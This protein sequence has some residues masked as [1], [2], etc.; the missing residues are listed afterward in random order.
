MSWREIDC[1][2][3]GQKVKIPWLWVLGLEMI[4]YCRGCR[5]HFKID[6]KL[7][8]LLSGA[9]WALAFASL[10]LIAYPTSA[11]TIYLAAGSFI[12]LGLLFSFLLRRTVLCRKYSP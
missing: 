3:C 10:Q 4:F 1:P 8:A 12:P 9:G 2:R 6:Y 11:F 7:G 5:K